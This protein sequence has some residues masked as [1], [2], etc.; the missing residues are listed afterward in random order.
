MRKTMGS[1]GE[2][3]EPSHRQGVP[4]V[5]HLGYLWSAEGYRMPPDRAL[6]LHQLRKPTNPSELSRLGVSVCQVPPRTSESAST[7]LDLLK[8]D[9][10]TVW[11]PEL[12]GAFSKVI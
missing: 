8:K 9:A 10:E 11:T 4:E 2:D 6:V 3:F 7:H 1:S 12:D 5:N